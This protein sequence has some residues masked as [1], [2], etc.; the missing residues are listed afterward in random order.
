[1]TG[2]FIQ[3]VVKDL[4]TVASHI[5]AHPRGYAGFEV[6][7][8]KVLLHRVDLDALSDTIYSVVFVSDCYADELTPEEGRVQ[9]A[10]MRLD[11]LLPLI[12]AQQADI[13]ARMAA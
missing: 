6:E 1:M 7:R 13:Q 2:D 12:H 11:R 4:Y 5:A 3:R 9:S 10:A 8:A